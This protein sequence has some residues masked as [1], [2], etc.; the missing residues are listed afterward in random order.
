MNQIGLHK[1]AVNHVNYKYPTEYLHKY[2]VKR[3]KYTNIKNVFLL[4]LLQ[5]RIYLTF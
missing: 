5:V 3:G 1:R 2:I 4:N